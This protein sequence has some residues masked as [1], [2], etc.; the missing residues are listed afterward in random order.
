[1]AGS[2]QYF[3]DFD[4]ENKEIRTLDRDFYRK[5]AYLLPFPSTKPHFYADFY[6]QL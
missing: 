4:I 5:T 6:V 2:D 1:M 3:E